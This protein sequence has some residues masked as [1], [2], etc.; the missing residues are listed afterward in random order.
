MLRRVDD[1]EPLTI[2]VYKT[3]TD[4]FAGRISFFKVYSGVVKNEA[5]ADELRPQ[6]VGAVC[7]SLDH[8][9]TEG[10]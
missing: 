6:G 7:A 9:G 4:P 1:K 10:G 8:A 3:M 5:T 2:Y